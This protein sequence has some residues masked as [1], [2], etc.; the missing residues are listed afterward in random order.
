MGLKLKSFDKNGPAFVAAGILAFVCLIHALSSWAPGFRELQR[1]EWMTYDWRVRQA[2]T[3]PAPVATNLAAIFIDDAG[4]QEVNDRYG[5]NFPW[6]RQL[7]GKLIRELSA[8]G[9]KAVGFDI[10]FLNRDPDYSETRV[11]VPRK[12]SVSSD[13]FFAL[14]LRRAGNITLGTPGNMASNG[15]KAVLPAPIFATNAYALG[16]A[17]SVSD[18]DGV[19]R[20]V[21]AFKDD[22]EHGRLWHLGIVL[23][24][25]ELKLNLSNAIIESE[26][27]IL[28]GEPGVERTIPVD[29]NGR[30]LI[31]WNI[32]WNDKRMAKAGFEDLLKLDAARQQGERIEPEF[33]D[34]LVFVGS[35]GSGNN[36][37][38]VGASPLE[39][40]TYLVS[41][42]WNVA[43]SVIT[44]RF[45]DS[46]STT[47]DLLL[48]I[49]LGAMAAVL[50][51]NFRA[52]WPTLGVV[53][54]GVAYG[55]VALHLYISLRLWVPIF[56]PVMGGLVLTHVGIVTY[57][58]FFEQNEKRRVR[59]VFSKLVS[60]NVVHEL[61]NAEKLNLGGARR[62]ITVFFA[63]VR[64]FTEM[65]DSAQARA[66][67]FVRTHNLSPEQAESHFDDQAK[68][69]LNTVNVYLASIADQIKK[70]GGTL[71]KYIGDCVMAFWGA[72]TPNERHALDCVRAAIDAQRALYELNQQRF[73]ENK[74]READNVT[75]G[76]AGQPPLAM[77]PL[78]SLGTGINTGTAI[79]GLMGS[80]AHILNYTVFGREVN[81]ASR[82]EGV[83]GR[84][85]IIIGESTYL[86]LKRDDAEFA[87]TCVELPPV[88]VKGIQRAI[89]IYEVPW[90]VVANSPTDFVSAP[91]AASSSPKPPA[92]AS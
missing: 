92:K 16:H 83:S 48:I 17:T 49:L 13:E 77:L 21:E 91:V 6:P 65:T 36:I 3:R 57:Q 11:S 34:K 20:R 82:L 25:Q 31:D 90:K 62:H 89:K 73:A 12:G 74:K 44:G 50:T 4:L 87:S 5:F 47:T 59:N 2:F 58:V 46:T 15:W 61:L 72:P 30:F 24:A 66:E 68:E 38:D 1:L 26:R 8:Q 81:L 64:G 85:R 42:H 63:D 27:I 53:I 23:A 54:I 67:E 41:K 37:S 29:S 52:P 60:P 86:E 28:R 7:H 32:A 22:P 70:H 75:R 79:V 35:I 84:G 43:N 80:D 10:F 76:A 9:A 40:E 19:L 39:K 56:M 45:I 51:W 78:L 88:T 33:R 14:E 55:F 18:R 71:D 69:T